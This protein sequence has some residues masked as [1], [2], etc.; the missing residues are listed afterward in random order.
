MALPYVREA[1]R[2]TEGYVRRELGM[3]D[4]VITTTGVIAYGVATG[5]VTTRKI[6]RL[7]WRHENFVARPD[8]S[9]NARN[10]SASA[11]LSFV[12]SF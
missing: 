6:K 10:D 7:G 12:W 11:M 1:R 4:W 8:V 3:A 2:S 5:E 9:Y